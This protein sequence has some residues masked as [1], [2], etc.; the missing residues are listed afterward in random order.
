MGG[1]VQVMGFVS[2]DDYES[3]SPQVTLVVCPRSSLG[4]TRPDSRC[5]GITPKSVSISPSLILQEPQMGLLMY[6]QQRKGNETC[7]LVSGR[8]VINARPN[9]D[10]LH[11]KVWPSLGHVTQRSSGFKY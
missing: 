3:A 10:S 2:S 7:Q 11:D 9:A 1:D 8:N 6:L 5:G 4:Q